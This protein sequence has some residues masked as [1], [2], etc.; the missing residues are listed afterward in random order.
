MIDLGALKTLLPDGYEATDARISDAAIPE[1]AP[2]DGGGMRFV[3]VV[4]PA[5][6]ARG[7]AY[8][9]VPYPEDLGDDDTPF[10]ARYIVD[11]LEDVF[12]GG[13]R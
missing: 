8:A 12:S 7:P 6:D 10:L 5:R 2:Y 9:Y 13:A 11:A 3:R 4:A 1:L